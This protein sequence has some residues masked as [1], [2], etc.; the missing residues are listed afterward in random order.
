[1]LIFYL[2]LN[3]YYYLFVKETRLHSQ[4]FNNSFKE[5]INLIFNLKKQ[6]IDW[7]V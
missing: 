6:I 7:F 2:L 5:A 3:V 4:K 1:M